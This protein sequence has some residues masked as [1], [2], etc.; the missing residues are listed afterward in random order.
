MAVY[1]R[2]IDSEVEDLVVS[3]R[4][5]PT[6]S[7]SAGSARALT[8]KGKRKE[9]LLFPLLSKRMQKALEVSVEGD[10]RMSKICK[11]K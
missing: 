8:K 11:A 5:R 4:N 6:S 7:T 2:Y 1:T 10:Q 3:Q 9:S